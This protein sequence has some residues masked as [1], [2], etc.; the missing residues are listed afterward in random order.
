VEEA[1]AGGENAAEETV[2]EGEHAGGT[3]STG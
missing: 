1:E 2:N 3:S